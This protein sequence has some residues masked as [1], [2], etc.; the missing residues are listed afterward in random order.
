MP[1]LEG[2]VLVDPSTGQHYIVPS[3]GMFYPQ[4]YGYAPYAPGGH[5]PPHYGHYYGHPQQGYNGQAAPGY[6]MPPQY[7][8]ASPRYPAHATPPTYRRDSTRSSAEFYR[9]NHQEQPPF[10]RN[11]NTQGS[12]TSLEKFQAHQGWWA[13]RR[14]QGSVH[15]PETQTDVESS[16]RR[17]P[18]Q[19]MATSDNEAARRATQIEA[20]PPRFVPQKAVRMDFDLTKPLPE[21]EELRER[22]EREKKAKQEDAQRPTAFTIS[23]GDDAPKS[24]PPA[25]L[26]LQDAARKSGPGKRILAG[27]K[28]AAPPAAPQPPEDTSKH[29]LLN[30]LLQGPLSS[31]AQP[32][33]PE[34]TPQLQG[35]RD[36]DAVSEAGTFVIG[37]GESKAAAMMKTR[38]VGDSSDSDAS[39]SSSE[40]EQPPP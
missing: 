13:P 9:Q 15:D 14:S 32:L 2:R 12:G 23:F 26:S 8:G 38:I 17:S 28:A 25:E 24:G 33:S 10:N 5:P 37:A 40:D 27:R 16:P 31:N 18:R 39:E 6:A 21:E 36:N 29:Y 1:P 30:R 4:P 3:Q 22:R 20:P 11:Y 34:D 7:A 19:S 35:R